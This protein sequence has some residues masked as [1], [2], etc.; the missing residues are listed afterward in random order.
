M[1]RALAGELDGKLCI[2]AHGRCVVYL[3]IGAIRSYGEYM[4]DFKEKD[5]GDLFFGFYAS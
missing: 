1:K 2:A 3:Y 4:E 5:A